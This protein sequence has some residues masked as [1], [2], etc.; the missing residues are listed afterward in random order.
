M[1]YIKGCQAIFMTN[2][3]TQRPIKEPKTPPE[4]KELELPL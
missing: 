2:F 3:L 4:V 1:A